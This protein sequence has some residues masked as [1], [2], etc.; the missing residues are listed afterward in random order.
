MIRIPTLRISVKSS[1]CLHDIAPPISGAVDRKT[2]K[3][4]IYN[5]S[6]YWSFITQN[7]MHNYIILSL[8]WS[9]TSNFHI[10]SKF[11]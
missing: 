4:L 11:L 6:E 3:I 2:V 8:I 10:L 1:Y 9:K 7:E 5:D